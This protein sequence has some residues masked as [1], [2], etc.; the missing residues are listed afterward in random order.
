MFSLRDLIF[1][2]EVVSQSQ[3]L[4]QSPDYQNGSASQLQTQRSLLTDNLE[5]PSSSKDV[6]FKTDLNKK[7]K[8][9]HVTATAYKPRRLILGDD[10]YNSDNDDDNT[11]QEE[12]KLPKMKKERK[13]PTPTDKSI[14]R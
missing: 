5:P 12:E 1:T 2:P 3:Q 9:I 10:D 6:R 13:Q 8:S 14:P 11:E 4:F 7:N